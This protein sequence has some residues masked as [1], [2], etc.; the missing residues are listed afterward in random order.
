[1]SNKS[2]KKSSKKS[3]KGMTLKKRRKRQERLAFLVLLPV[4]LLGLL[5]WATY[6]KGLSALPSALTGSSTTSQSVASSVDQ[7]SVSSEGETAAASTEQPLPQLTTNAAGVRLIAHRG[8]ILTH[9]ESSAA[10]FRAASEQGFTEWEA[11]VRFTADGVPVLSH[12]DEIN[13]IAR[14]SDGQELTSTVLI[15]QSTY[16][17]LA[18]YDFGLY[19]G[20]AFRGTKLL[21]FEDFIALAKEL[22][23]Q[24]L[25]LELKVGPTAKE[26]KNLYRTIAEQGFINKVGWQSFDLTSLSSLGEMDDTMQLEYVTDGLL[27]SEVAAV[28]A[29][30]NG[31]R[32]LVISLPHDASDESIRLAQSTGY[33]TYIFTIDVNN[34]HLVPHFYELGVDALM[35]DLLYSDLAN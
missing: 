28:K 21:T 29:L 30:D 23:V 13:K 16:E 35:T 2:K 5:I 22:D 34:H 11:D 26:K 6:Q 4:V 31:K 32:Q 33:Q 10:G 8:Q 12:E 1:M 27:E 9:P 17:E 20:E 24:F 25:H 3:K 14:T 18:Q 19:K 7:S 15:S